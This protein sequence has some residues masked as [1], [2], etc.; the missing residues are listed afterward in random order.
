[1]EDGVVGVE[2]EERGSGDAV[3]V[4]SMAFGSCRR[5]GFGWVWGGDDEDDEDEQ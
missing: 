3:L 5:V 4:G 1:M 2:G